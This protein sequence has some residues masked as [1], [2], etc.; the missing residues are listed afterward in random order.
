MTIETTSI[1]RANC[2][3]DGYVFVKIEKV[4]AL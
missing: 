3:P 1:S 2:I 4:L